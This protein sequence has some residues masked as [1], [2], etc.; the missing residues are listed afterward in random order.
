V[1]NTA[2][3]AAAILTLIL[4]K[5]APRV[6]EYVAKGE[7]AIEGVEA[8]GGDKLIKQI[9][10]HLQRDLIGRS[11]DEEMEMI[12]DD[13]ALVAQYLI[14]IRAFPESAEAGHSVKGYA[15]APLS[16]NYAARKE[17]GGTKIGAIRVGPRPPVPN[18]RLTSQTAKALG[19]IRTERLRRVLGF[20]TG[21]E[22]RIAESL[23]R[24]NEFWPLDAQEKEAVLNLARA[25]VQRRI[26]P[27]LS[28][29]GGRRVR[30]RIRIG[31]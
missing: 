18:Q 30:I 26:A 17:K 2:A 16:R 27:L 7:L 19:V 11:I 6:A 15:F 13:M 25:E 12:L 1:P 22:Q 28:V 4:R 21:R 8:V 14:L 31:R 5:R 20:R 23:Q 24:R 9:W 3:N 29:T 10:R